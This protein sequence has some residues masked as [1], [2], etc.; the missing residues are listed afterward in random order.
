MEIHLSLRRKNIKEKSKFT[1]EIIK[2]V[3][4]ENKL[5][6]RAKIT[7]VCYHI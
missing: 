1:K 2:K 6:S 3:T 5:I 4:A 7:H